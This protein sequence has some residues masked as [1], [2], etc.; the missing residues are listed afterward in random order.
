MPPHPSIASRSPL[1]APRQP[2]LPVKEGEIGSVRTERSRRALE[3]TC[4]SWDS[5]PC[6][7]TSLNVASIDLP[8]FMEP[9]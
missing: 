5:E 3:Q 6:R 1:F 9:T 2:I 4:V 7:S 8:R